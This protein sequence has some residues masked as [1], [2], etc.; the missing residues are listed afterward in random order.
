MKKIF[1]FF[2][3]L[4]CIATLRSEQVSGEC[5]PAIT[6]TLETSTGAFLFDGAGLMY[7][8]THPDILPWAQYR[9]LIRTVS[10]KSGSSFPNLSDWAFNECTNLKSVELPTTVN[11]IGAAAFEDCTSLTSF[12]FTP[13]M[14]L[15]DIAF[16]RSGL[17]SV[18][19]PEGVTV[20]IGT[21]RECHNITEFTVSSSNNALTAVDGV[22]FSKD[23]TTIITF[24]VADKRNRTSYAIPEGT[25]TIDRG[26]F[27][28]S[29]L[30]SLSIP[31]TMSYIDLLACSYMTNLKTVYCYAATPPATL[32]YQT[33]QGCKL[34]A[35]TLY[36]P[37]GSKA[38]YASDGSWNDFGKIEEING[39]GIEDIYAPE[40]QPTKVFH[41]GIILIE[42]DGNTYTVSGKQLR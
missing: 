34:S 24:P 23:K 29:K 35:A 3:A 33:F 22:L 7:N 17:T 5:G 15:G 36:V 4:C 28:Y 37:V 12:T 14:K 2:V 27:S 9:T 38:L 41:N 31:A 13:N 32:N 19:L 8:Y 26:A 11:S 40:S 21:F 39:T 20:G 16:M 25:V 42:K 18:Y 6:W 10:Y 1:I 30:T